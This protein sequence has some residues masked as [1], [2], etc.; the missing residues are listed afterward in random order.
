MRLGERF[1]RLLGDAH[2]LQH[3]DAAARQ[4]MCEVFAGDQFHDQERLAVGRLAVV[5][6]A[7]DVGVIER[8]SGARLAQETRAVGG[9]FRRRARKLDGHAA[10]EVQV[11]GEVDDAHAPM[12]Q[13]ADDAV[14]RY[15][16][17]DHL[18]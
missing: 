9:I 4:A 3:G 2:G 17:A 5:V 6:N 7:G 12:P 16:L 1:R 14:M 11:L 10:L 15:G 18:R 13:L 8:G